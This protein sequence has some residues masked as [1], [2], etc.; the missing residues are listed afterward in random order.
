[1]AFFWKM[2]TFSDLRAER[3]L[4]D[5]IPRIFQNIA[6]GLV[7]GLTGKNIAVGLAGKIDGAGS[8]VS[9]SK[10]QVYW[11]ELAVR[12]WRVPD[13]IYFIQVRK[14]PHFL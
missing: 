4:P 10:I 11:I 3:I 12:G 7:V 6:Q 13:E 8:A 2:L 9:D 5:L 14:L 1:M